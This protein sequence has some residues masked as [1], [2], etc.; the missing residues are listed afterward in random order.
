[1]ADSINSGLKTFWGALAANLDQAMICTQQVSRVV[2]LR[3][4][5]SRW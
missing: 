2:E 1:M 4:E 5:H 3:L